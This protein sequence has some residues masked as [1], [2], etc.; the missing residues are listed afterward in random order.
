MTTEFAVPVDSIKRERDLDY[1]MFVFL[2]VKCVPSPQQAINHQ[3]V[4]QKIT[5]HH[6]YYED[7]I[8]VKPATIIRSNI[9]QPTK[10][11]SSLYNVINGWKKPG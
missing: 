7:F 8:A 1:L 9:R 2:T 4:R 3:N 5:C 11:A 6:Y 10:R